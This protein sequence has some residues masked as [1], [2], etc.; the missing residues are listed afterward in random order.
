[1]RLSGGAIL[2]VL[3]IFNLVNYCD[4]VMVNGFP[5][6]FGAFVEECLSVPGQEQ[7]FYMGLIG[8]SFMLTYAVASLFFGHLH[9]YYN[10][11]VLMS[12][13][14]CVW[15][16]AVFGSGICFW[17][18]RS[19]LA[20]WLFVASRALSGV[21]EAAT[22][23]LMP[24]Y[25]EDFAPVN[26]QALWLAVLFASKPVGSALGYVYGA[27]LAPP[28]MGWGWAYLLEALT[29]APIAVSFAFLPTA[30]II[31][32]RRAAAVRSRTAPL[33]LNDAAVDDDTAPAAVD[34]EQ[35]TGP[36]PPPPGVLSQLTFLLCSP[37]Y[38]LLCL[39]FAAFTA[40]TNAL[41]TFAPLV[42]MSLGY[43]ETQSTASAVFGATAAIAGVLGT[44]IGGLATDCATRRVLRG[45]SGSAS[46]D[47]PRGGGDGSVEPLSHAYSGGGA[48]A[49]P[50]PSVTQVDAA[51]PTTGN[52]AS[53]LSQPAPSEGI[54]DAAGASGKGASE[55]QIASAWHTKLREAR[56][57]VGVITAQIAVASFFAV[58][59]ALVLFHR[60]TTL[61]RVVY[62]GVLCAT[63]AF[64]FATSA[65]ISRAIML[66]VPSHVRPFA[67]AMS[68]LLLHG[69]GDVPSPP[70]VGALIGAWAPNCSIVIVNRTT[71]AIIPDAGAGSG[72]M[73]IIN[74]S[75]AA[76]PNGTSA[77]GY[78][79][80]QRGLLDV[81]LIT[82]LYCVSAVFWWGLCI[83][84]LT[85]RLRTERACPQ[86]KG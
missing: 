66:V 64:A 51:I 1:M 15:I 79:P 28:P 52:F 14:A 30:K 82:G 42:L 56:A 65:G 75:C 53:P 6:Q 49:P 58:A 38:I 29:M 74:P 61:F 45:A 47:T 72:G 13:G 4:R 85:R 12:L 46:G 62:L 3:S 35:T 57:I 55:A 21:G 50:S 18:P 86:L 70:I 25:V 2:A 9:H 7:A 10:T 69:L 41:A 76:H 67:L 43:F 23:T 40:S 83:V 5:V 33:L 32:R 80:E 48:P 20:F 34:D 11:F 17:L 8:P 36:T 44:P 39:G 81:F 54:S 19:P 63:V 16:V 84:V 71:H 27:M 59:H 78:S 73:P 24:A 22:V 60:A 37:T 77:D 68:S 26:A 31:K